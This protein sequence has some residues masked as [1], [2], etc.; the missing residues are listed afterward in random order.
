V[1]FSRFGAD[2]SDIYTFPNS[3]GDYECCACPLI[4]HHFTTRD[5]STFIGHL[6]AHI[7]A[8]HTVPDYTALAVLQWD[9]EHPNGWSKVAT[10]VRAAPGLYHGAVR[11]DGVIVARC[12]HRHTRLDLARTCAEQTLMETP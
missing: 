8:G 11:N 2:G 10:F 5:V 12:N 4:E 6:D 7:E 9:D 3:S 1:S